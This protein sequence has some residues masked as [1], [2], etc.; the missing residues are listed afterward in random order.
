MDKGESGQAI[1]EMTI[2]LIAIMVVFL[3]VIFAFAIGKANIETLLDCRGEADGYAANGAAGDAGRPIMTWQTGGDERMYTNDDEAVV[4][5]ND[6]S[7]LFRGELRSDEVDLVSG[8]S[9]SYVKHNFAADI[10]D[11]SM[12]FLRMANLTSYEKSVDPATEA[13]IEELKGGFQSLIYP[14]DLVVRNAVFMPIFSDENAV[15]QAP[16]PTP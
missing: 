15:S 4:G 10:A 1:A 8:F 11:Y 16:A 6:N 7:D 14:S 2:A 13:G 5:T 12:L 3:G 9:K